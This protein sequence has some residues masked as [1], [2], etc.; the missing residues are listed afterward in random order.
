MFRSLLL[1]YTALFFLS[2][3]GPFQNNEKIT[4]Y[5]LTQPDQRLIMPDILHE[6]SDVTE[7]DASSFACIQDE[8]GILFIYDAVKN[9]I[10]K[11]YHFNI[12]GDYEGIARVGKQIYVLRSDGTLYEIS[13]YSSDNFK[14]TTYVT[15]VPAANNE[16]LCYDKAN[17]RLLIGC[18]SNL[19][20]GPE[21]KDKRGIYAFDLG[22]KKLV[23]D[24]VFEFDINDI[25]QFA[26]KHNIKLPERAKKDN[27]P[28]P[29]IKFRIS[30]IAIHPLNGKLY[31]LSA[32]D[33]LFFIFDMKGGIEHMEQ[34][35]PSV[36]NKSEGITFFENG[37]MLITNEGQKTKPTLLCFN[38]KGM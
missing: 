7:V 32:T 1:L 20:K 14:L 6:V 27:A 28:E 35:N 5:N 3:A 15:G 24:P 25:K 18:K 34:L 16:G 26:E 33:H 22:T 2:C 19:G 36:F 12:D 38:Y 17:N 30:A 23:R 29:V 8:N 21:F 31:L 9:E 13:D 10:K 37:D 11:Q 4:G